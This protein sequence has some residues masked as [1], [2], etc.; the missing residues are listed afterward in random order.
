MKI[1]VKVIVHNFYGQIGYAGAVAVIKRRI[2][3]S[4]VNFWSF[5]LENEVFPGSDNITY[6][7]IGN[8]WYKLIEV[9]PEGE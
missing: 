5:A 1:D 4:R 7:C 2:F 6:I 3:G 8:V 9:D